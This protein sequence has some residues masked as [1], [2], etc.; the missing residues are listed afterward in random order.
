MLLFIKAPP[1]LKKCQIIML[2]NPCVRELYDDGCNWPN[3]FL[4]FNRV[5]DRQTDRQTS[6]AHNS[7]LSCENVKNE[8]Y[9]Q[10]FS[11]TGVSKI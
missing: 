6:I 11:H 2:I 4:D 1:P 8:K 3:I 5:V 7:I 9:I 10:H